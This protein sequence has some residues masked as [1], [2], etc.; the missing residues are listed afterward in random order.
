MLYPSAVFSAI[1]F[2][3]TILAGG[4]IGSVG[5]GK[6]WKKDS[7]KSYRSKL[8]PPNW[9]FGLIWTFMYL[10]LGAVIFL[11]QEDVLGDTIVRNQMQILFVL[12]IPFNFIWTQV[13]VRNS[14][15]GFVCMMFLVFSA[16]WMGVIGIL[17]P[18][19]SY[20]FIASCL[21][22]PY[23]IWLLFASYLNGV[24]VYNQWTDPIP[25]DD[26]GL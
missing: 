14:A 11:I 24:F 12:H 6:F 1:V 22:G 5:V 21:L 26:W 10:L 15:Y 4:F 18:T 16:G 17:Q 8:S 7:Y 13:F 23:M 25:Q 2:P 19:T 9:I 20:L 3:L